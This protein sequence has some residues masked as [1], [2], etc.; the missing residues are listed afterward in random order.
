MCVCVYVLLIVCYIDD[1][2]V[3]EFQKHH[4]YGIQSIKCF[5]LLSGVVNHVEDQTNQS[6]HSKEKRYIYEGIIYIYI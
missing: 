6:I 2:M 5:L 4:Y 1:D 3:N